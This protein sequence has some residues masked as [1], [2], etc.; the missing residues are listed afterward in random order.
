MPSLLTRAG[1]STGELRSAARSAWLGRTV[2]LGY[3]KRDAWDP[4]TT[5]SFPDGREAKVASL[6]FP[7][8]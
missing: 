7:G 8:P 2:G 5:V 3:I 1:E 6:P 4:G